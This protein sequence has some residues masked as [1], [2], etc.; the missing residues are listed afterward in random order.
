MHDTH[1]T[2]LLGRPLSH[3]LTATAHLRALRHRWFMR[4]PT[5]S[6]QADA[7]ASRRRLR[8][9]WAEFA[10][11][12]SAGAPWPTPR[13]IAAPPSPPRA[14]APIAARCLKNCRAMAAAHAATRR[15]TEAAPFD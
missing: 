10:R 13:K 4:G 12:L 14:A 3:I 8:E 6:E 1:C 5:A 9:N 11:Q 2:D 15:T 7:S